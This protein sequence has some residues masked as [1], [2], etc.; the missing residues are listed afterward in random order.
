MILENQRRL[1][2]IKKKN[3]NTFYGHEVV[4]AKITKKILEELKFPLKDIEKITLLVRNHMFFSDPD[5]ITLSAVR[6]IIRNVGGA[7]NV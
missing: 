6:R 3:K 2:E 5:K 7:E 4:G 1:V